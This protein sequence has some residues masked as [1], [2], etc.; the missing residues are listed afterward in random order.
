M[1]AFLLTIAL[2]T[3]VGSLYAQDPADFK[4]EI[5]LSG[6]ICTN[7]IPGGSSAL[8]EGSNSSWN[9]A[10][11][12][13]VDYNINENWQIGGEI[14]AAKWMTTGSWPVNDAFG[15]SLQSQKITFIIANP[16][17][18]ACLQVNRVVPFYS[19]YKHFNKANFY[20][21]V[22]LGLLPTVNDGGITYSKYDKSPDP[23]LTYVSQYDYGFGIGYTA[24]IQVGYSY[25]IVPKFGV[26]VELAGR[27][28][29]VGT[30]ETR[31]N[32]ENTHYDLLYFPATIGLRYRLD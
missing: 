17:I 4:I 15:Q 28:A 8:Y 16:A 2:V 14:G 19:K 31:Y 12:I 25:Y 13:K 27:Y 9:P 20:Y 21:G 3:A 29:Y 11:S 32:H 22:S 5:G 23:A 24:G 30:N 10:G 6:G 18:S 26:N 1:K 7:T